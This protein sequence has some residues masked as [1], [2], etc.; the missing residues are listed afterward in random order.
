MRWSVAS[1]LVLL[2]PLLALTGI[3]VA[4]PAPPADPKLPDR[5]IP[6][7]V[8]AGLRI[9]EHQF[10]LALAQ[11]CAPERCYAKGCVYVAHS[12]VDQPA[13]GSL[14]GLNLEAGP[15]SAS[16][17]IYLTS[18]ECSFAHEPSVTGRDARA[19]AARLRAKL[20]RGWT[21]VDVS[22]ES[23]QTI[24]ARLRESP[25]PPPEPAP[26]TAASL[27]P[28]TDAAPPSAAPAAPATWD[29]SVALRE[30]WEGLLP[31]FA[32][33]IGLFL[34]TLAV[35]L[36]IW[37]TRRLGRES[38]EEQALLA[39]MLAE[40]E[41]PEPEAEPAPEAE[42]PEAVISARYAA[43]RER[44]ADA[45]ADDPV[46]RALVADLLRSGDRR[47]L[48]K[49]VMLFPDAFPKAFPHGGAYASAKYALAEF[50]KAADAAS[51]PPDNDFFDALD[52]YAL[53]SALT[54]HPDTEL[55]RTLHDEFGA[56]AL[57]DLIGRLPSRYG[58]LLFA[59]APDAMQHEALGLLNQRQLHDTIGQL[60]RSNRMDSVETEYLLGVLDA[61]R[62][63]AAL[64][65]PPAGPVSDRGAEFDAAGALSLLLPRLDAGPRQALIQATA[66]RHNGRLPSWVGGTLHG[67]ML[68][69]LTP[70]TRADL[71]LEVEVDALA[72]WL[73][74]QPDAVRGQLLSEAPGA[75]QL[76]I[77]A[78]APPTAPAEQYAL[79]NS[80]R[81][82][83][84]EGLPRAMRRDGVQ[85]EALLG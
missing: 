79:A 10:G 64:P 59:L 21:T 6:P 4:Q 34:F 8:V 30:F 25:P 12:V 61:L 72:A 56:T 52:R 43:W 54:A 24:P 49:A 35:L 53:A 73:A 22:F 40:A 41:R 55:I 46:L 82:T 32:W 31:H 63:G 84:T 66:A 28:A 11:D 51:L 39:Q 13:V 2:I 3:A 1:L 68:L 50:I 83:L 45:P 17:Q 47:L 62:T 81:A 16:E 26:Q 67:G 76:A 15:G 58:A 69:Q 70:E 48:A 78:T 65:A 44:L 85:F 20:S 14:P 60:L 18:A 36:I 29:G 33:M 77:S 27:A 37:A 74:L 5:Q 71:L 7:A 42:S 23:L 19:L 80:A 9:L 75:L 57:V 38:P